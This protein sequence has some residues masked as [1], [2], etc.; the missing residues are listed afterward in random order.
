ME[1]PVLVGCVNI[2][3]TNNQAQVTKKV[4]YKVGTV[5]ILR[6]DIREMFLEVSQEKVLTTKL[7]LKDVTVHKKF[8]AEGK[9]SVKFNNDKCTVFINN[10]APGDKVKFK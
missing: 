3:W 8:M 9:A 1:E 4:L 6:N 10:A 5:R 2:E 7:R